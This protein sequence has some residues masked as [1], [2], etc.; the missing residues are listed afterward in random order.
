MSAVEAILQHAPQAIRDSAAAVFAASD[1]VAQTC[2]ANP[3]LLDEL[4]QSQ[5]LINASTAADFAARWDSFENG[6]AVSE[7]IFM[8]AL[9]R[10]RCQEMLRIAWRD[11]A[12]WAPLSETLAELSAFA[13]TAIRAAY[14]YARS[15]LCE[16]YGEPLASDGIP[17]SLLILAMGKLGGG[18][19]NFSS[20]IDL[21][22]LFPEHGETAGSV[23]ISNEEFFTR[24]GQ[25]LIRLL[26]AATAEGLV[27]RVDMRLRPF[28]DS[29]PLVVSFAFLEDYL[30]RQ[31]RDW[32][33]YA[34]IKARPITAQKEYIALYD[35]I[36][37]PFVYRRYLD[38]G[39]FASLRDMK[40]L[41]EREVMRRELQQDVKLGPGGIREIE[42]IVQTF[43]LIRG[44]RRKALQHPSLLHILPL[45]DDNKLLGETAVSELT[46]AYAFLRRL[47]NRLQMLAD[48]QT[49]TLPT[50]PVHQGRLAVAMGYPSWDSLLQQLNVHRAT[51]TRHFA[52]LVLNSADS[53]SV[54][55]L[56]ASLLQFW[57]SEVIVSE[58]DNCC[59]RCVRT[60]L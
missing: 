30:Q 56:D 2:A 59:C 36:I 51:V 13:D 52:V 9:R 15:R 25:L 27:F 49:H 43:Q 1:F 4:I 18:E 35:D 57:D 31:G 12:A 3:K 41:I 21:L 54:D 8:S 7:S 32:E 39:V 24:L 16:Q 34:Y 10:W 22:F 40:A 6:A 45:L 28:G 14:Q 11:L 26:N 17:Q 53:S 42:F 48:Q 37:K 58:L 38:F 20:D 29:G 55:V 60:N 46:V 33:R 47:E 44:G 5:V 23:S 19:L 50:E